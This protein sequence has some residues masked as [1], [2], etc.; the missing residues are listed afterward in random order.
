ML[1]LF[2]KIFRVLNSEISPNRIA[3]GFCL[4]M[5]LGLTPLMSL[6]NLFVLFVLCILAVN[7][8]AA[9]LGLGLFT[10]FAYLFDPLFNQFGSYLLHLDALQSLWVSAYHSDF[11]RLMK[12]NNTLVM[13]SFA[14]SVL[15]FLPLFFVT[16]FLIIKY[17]S[18]VLVWIQ[19]LRIV[20]ALKSSKWAQRVQSA[21]ETV[22]SS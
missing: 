17:R 16:K 1:Q 8:A 10:L 13:G 4:G 21:Y 12:F 19:K 3:T 9:L 2:L 15:T 18:K 7:F 20:Q 6:H 5:M 22:Y 14:A 11:W